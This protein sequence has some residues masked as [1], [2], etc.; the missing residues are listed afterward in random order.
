MVVVPVKMHV[1]GIFVIPTYINEYP[2]NFYVVFQYKGTTNCSM[3]PISCGSFPP[4]KKILLMKMK[5][6]IHFEV[7]LS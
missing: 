6:V 5:C 2:I 1:N 4:P 7:L 3:Y